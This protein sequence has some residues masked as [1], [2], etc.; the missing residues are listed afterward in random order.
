MLTGDLKKKKKE[1]G[2]YNITQQSLINLIEVCIPLQ[3]EKYFPLNIQ[4]PSHQ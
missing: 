4:Y 2:E 1:K 3:L